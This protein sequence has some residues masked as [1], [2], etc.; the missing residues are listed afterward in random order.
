[1]SSTSSAN[2]STGTADKSSE[3][4]RVEELWTTYTYHKVGLLEQILSMW[5]KIREQGAAIRGGCLP[6]A[7]LPRTISCVTI[8]KLLEAMEGMGDLRKT[9]NSFLSNA[10]Y[11]RLEV[12]SENYENKLW[13]KLFKRDSKFLKLRRKIKWGCWDLLLY[14][15]DEPTPRI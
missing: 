14:G 13:G 15:S 3:I 9:E 6:V 7:I 11:T 8:A 1:M 10:L 2:V 5:V 12:S 4:H